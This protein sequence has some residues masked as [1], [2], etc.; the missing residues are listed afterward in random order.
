MLPRLKAV[1]QVMFYKDFEDLRRFCFHIFY[2]HKMGFFEY[3]RN[4][5]EIVEVAGS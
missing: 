3:W 5:W 1:P 2:R 4:L